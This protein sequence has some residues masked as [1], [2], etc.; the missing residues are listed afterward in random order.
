MFVFRAYLS[1]ID[2]LF[3]TF[4]LERGKVR[5]DLIE[6]FKIMRVNMMFIAIYGLKWMN[7]VEEPTLCHHYTM[8][9]KT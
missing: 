8:S 7:V 2:F 4:R 6:T 9:H 1:R 3:A 5:S